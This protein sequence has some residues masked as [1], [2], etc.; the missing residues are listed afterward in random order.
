MKHQQVTRA[1]QHII[2]YIIQPYDFKNNEI[3]IEVRNDNGPQ[4]SAKNLRSFFQENGLNHVFTHPYTPQENGHIESFHSILSKS[5]EQY[6]FWSIEDLEKRLDVFYHKYNNERIH[7]SIAQLT[8][9]LFWRLWNEGNIQ[10]K[11]NS[12]RKIKFTIKGT[13]QQLSGNKN[14]RAAPC[15]NLNELDA[16]SNL[17]EQ[18][19]EELIKKNEIFTLKNNHRYKESPSIAPC[20]S[21]N[22]EDFSIFTAVN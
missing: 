10:R 17:N 21:K 11:E 4:F 14:Q 1:W 2:E 18:K 9:T 5:L 12:K 7:G 15:L 20:Q 16:H 22:M 8:P 3:H 19:V 6:S 13:Y